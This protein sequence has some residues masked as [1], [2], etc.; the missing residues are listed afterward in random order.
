MRILIYNDPGTLSAAGITRPKIITLLKKVAEGSDSR[1][2]VVIVSLRAGWHG[3]NGGY[4]PPWFTPKKMQQLRG[5][6]SKAYP[7]GIPPRLPDRFQLVEITLGT[8][9]ISYPCT[10]YNQNGFRLVFKTFNAHLAYIFAHELHHF[11]RYRHGLHG[12]EGEKG[13]DRWAAGRA[14][15]LGYS[16]SIAPHRL[17]MHRKKK[18]RYKKAS[19]RQKMSARYRQRIRKLR[20]WSLLKV[21]ESDNRKLPAGTIVRFIRPLRGSYRILVLD[22]NGDERLVPIEWLRVIEER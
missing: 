16:V 2:L 4:Y 7:K 5:P 21:T 19:K 20:R 18:K 17:G 12:I 3:W 14:M 15:E 11:R 1:R 10:E 9:R 6:W 13:A 8:D 22:P